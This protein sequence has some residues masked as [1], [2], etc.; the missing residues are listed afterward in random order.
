MSHSKVLVGFTY[1]V[2]SRAALADAIRLCRATTS[3][4]IVFHAFD[5]PQLI[6]V[7]GALIPLERD[8]EERLLACD[9]SYARGLGVPTR[10]ITSN[11]AMPGAMLKSIDHENPDLVVVGTHDRRG[12]ERFLSGSIAR[13]LLRDSAR[14]VLVVRPP[15]TA[16][17]EPLRL[18]K[19]IV[20]IDFL[21]ASLRALEDAVW[22]AKA[23]GARVCLYHVIRPDSRVEHDPLRRPSRMLDVL[24]A[25]TRANGV[26]CESHIAVGEPAATLVETSEDRS[27]VVIAVGTH[28]RS[29]ASRILFGGFA[30]AVLD[31]AHC[32]VLIA[33][34]H[35]RAIGERIERPT[36]A[37]AR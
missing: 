25:D 1:D 28:N 26:E 8:A 27:D 10:L 21:P 36:A 20:G 13:R 9:V 32:P 30:E 22:L 2:P 12:L 19:I 31:L 15:R 35:E 33:H 6:P 17:H 14:P 7:P 11:D 3:E 18:G 24:A 37:I 34:D 23:S 5:A 29:R 16:E 4:L